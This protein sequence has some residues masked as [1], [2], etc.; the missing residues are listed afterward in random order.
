MKVRMI[1][2]DEVRE[3]PDHVAQKLVDAGKAIEV[4][5]IW[6]TAEEL[7]ALGIEPVSEQPSAD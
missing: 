5:H 7:R 4:I 2:N 1:H 3:H 6:P